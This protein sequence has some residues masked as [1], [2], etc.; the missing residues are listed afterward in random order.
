MTAPRDHE[1]NAL[2]Q[3]ELVEV[4]VSVCF[5]TTGCGGVE[6]GIAH[7]VEYCKPLDRCVEALVE[8][9]CKM[10]VDRIRV[11]LR[12]IPMVAGEVET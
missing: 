11:R 2:Y 6:D 4:R 8:S 12:Q 1:R 7:S 5:H 9:S 10:L 3:E